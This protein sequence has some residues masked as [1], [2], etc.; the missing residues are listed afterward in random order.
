M[1]HVST[2]ICKHTVFRD[3]R[4]VDFCVINIFFIIIPIS[5]LGLA[6][7]FGVQWLFELI[8]S[9]RWICVTLFFRV[10]RFWRACERFHLLSQ[11]WYYYIYYIIIIIVLPSDLNF[12][13]RLVS[14]GFR[15][16][17]SP[18]L[19]LILRSLTILLDL[20][21]NYFKCPLPLHFLQVTG[22]LL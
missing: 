20:S 11:L 3:P 18:F 1:H 16:F 15:N 21:Q 7:P 13:V 6:F 17:L 12:S 10:R 4:Y 14:L 5:L 22:G 2:I 9:V 8:C 19:S